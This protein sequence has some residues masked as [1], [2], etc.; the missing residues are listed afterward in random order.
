MPEQSWRPNQYNTNASF[1]SKLGCSVVDLLEP[2]PG[3]TILDL[4]CGDGTLAAKIESKGAKVVGVDS[5]PEMVRAAQ[6]RGIE[7]YVMSGDALTFAGDFDAVFSNAALH[8]IKDYQRV[9]G[10]VNASLRPGGRFVGEFGAYG[11]IQRLITGMEASFARNSDFGIFKNPWFFPDAATYTDA[12]QSAG[13]EIETIATIPRP[14]PLATGVREWLKIFADHVISGFT[15]EQCERFLNEVEEEV[16][17]Y[18]YT[19]QE[20]WVA[21]Y[22]RLRFAAI[23]A[24]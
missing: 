20:G 4:G 3:E 14:T 15:D 10:G 24:R 11:N 9:I 5:S 18:L 22:V 8:W 17:P 7:A 6:A 12:L 21:D 1:V 19:S 23:K 16:R 2:K 13:F